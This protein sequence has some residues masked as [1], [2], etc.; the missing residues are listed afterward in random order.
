MRRHKGTTAVPEPGE[1]WPPWEAATASVEALESTLL[2][3]RLDEEATARSIEAAL[4]AL[5]TRREAFSILGLLDTRYTVDLLDQILRNGLADRDV[6]R[7][8]HLL[9]RLPY[10]VA[11]E[12]VPRSVEKLLQSEGDAQAYRRMAEL[13]DHL[14]LPD[15]LD[16]LR[17]QAVDSIDPDVREVWEDYGRPD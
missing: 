1:P 13:L 10:S 17:A 12:V 5:S 4:G 7:V 9:G 2:P 8:R 6:L 3:L 11:A 14:G 15:A 16:Q